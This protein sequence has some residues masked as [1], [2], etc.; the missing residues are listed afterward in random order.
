[1]VLWQLDDISFYASL[2]FKE[3]EVYCRAVLYSQVKSYFLLLSEE[4]VWNGS[5]KMHLVV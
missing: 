3:T 1:M 2:S 4:L 5:V